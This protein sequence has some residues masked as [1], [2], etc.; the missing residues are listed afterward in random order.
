MAN[1][2]R[3]TDARPA[4]D[5]ARKYRDHG[6]WRDLTPAA[7]LR[8]WARKT[9]DAVAIVNHKA[10]SG[11]E[12]ITYREYASQVDRVTAVLSEL[13]VGPGNVVTVQLPN[14]WQLN[15]IVLACARL[16][17][18]VAPIMTTIRARELELMLSRLEPVAHVT[19][20]EWDGYAHSA[21]VASIAGRL[22]S[23]KHRIIIGGRITPGEINLE[24]CIQEVD[25]SRLGT[26]H[27]AEDPD[28]VSMALFT[29]GTSGGPKAALHSF[30]TFYAGNAA[31]AAR[32]G[33][34]SAD[35]LYT[36]HALGHMLGQ[37]ISNM[38]SL[39]LGAQALITDTWDPEMAARLLAEYGVTYVTGAP[40]FID[41]IAAA[42]RSRSQELPRLRLVI[43]TGTTVPVS[44]TGIVRDALGVTLGGGWGMTETGGA[45]LTAPDEDPPDWAARSIGRPFGCMEADLRSDGEVSARNPGRLFVRGAN[46]CL[47]TVPRDGG[48]VNVLTDNDEGWYDTGDLAVPD[49]R[50]GLRLAGRA[51]DRI[52]GAFMI[53]AAD[54]EDAL[55]GHPDIA[56]A[57][58]VGYGP[59][60]E[61][62][63]AVVVSRKPLTLQEVH[64]YLDSIQMT[65]WYQPRRL[66]LVDQLPRN[67]AGKVSKH[68]LRSWLAG[69]EAS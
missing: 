43:A 38:L 62:A 13:G 20:Q 52:G 23:L 5:L 63:C 67:T 14:W 16:G 21:A 19:T 11:V 17:A 31:R 32:G 68:A 24:R 6:F 34:S 35:V 58:L 45:S 69:L 18:I 30:N 48:E 66:E 3:W 1:T 39:N 49:G 36:P 27:T 33:L 60:N 26:D 51:A 12:R 41:A 64:A 22:S 9:P 10:G 29:S 57:A 40:V 47:A 4:A 28:R 61:L 56:D 53:P 25:A 7:D 65:E 44:L 54:V 55:R 8:H 42:V 50:G 37:N 15:A 2:M 46:V 59:G